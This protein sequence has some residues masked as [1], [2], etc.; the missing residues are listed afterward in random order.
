MAW[1][2]PPDSDAAQARAGRALAL[3]G[4]LCFFLSAVE[5][6]IPRPLPFMRIGLANMPL[7]LALGLL[8]PRQYFALALLKLAGQGLIGG[9]FLSFI[10]LFSAAGTLSS[11]L[12][13]YALSR[14]PGIARPGLAGIG[15][16]GAMVSNGAQLFMARF[17]VFGEAARYLAPPFLAAGFV[18][19]IA[20]GLACERFRR[21]SLWIAWLSGEEVERPSGEPEAASPQMTTAR[22]KRRGDSLAPDALFAAG[23]LA[24]LAFLWD[25]SL[26]GHLAQF[27][28]FCLLAALSGRRINFAATAIFVAGVV[29]FNLLAPQGRVLLELGPLSVTQ[30]SLLLGLER[31]ITLSGLMLI[32][33]L[34]VRSDLRLPGRA[35]ALLA[36]TLRLL[37]RMAPFAERARARRPRGEAGLV[38]AIDGMLFELQSR[39]DSAAA[40]D[41]APEKPRRGLRRFLL[42]ALFVALTAAIGLAARLLPLPF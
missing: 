2:L 4:A 12:A 1:T 26:A 42:P 3:L 23:L 10:F 41:A 8:R 18:S 25:R 34:A 35:G 28:F 5:H 9:T 17:F 7:L 29:F 31:A 39:D 30:G 6:L 40:L 13:M 33:K 19:G 16:A 22:A 32:S 24:A 21:R 38:R 36:Q 27:L 20:L 37:E 14:L 11:A 15:C